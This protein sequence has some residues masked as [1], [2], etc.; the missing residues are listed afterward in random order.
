MRPGFAVV[1]HPMAHV[2]PVELVIALNAVASRSWWFEGDEA[3]S[4]AA[5]LVDASCDPVTAR[6]VRGLL[7]GGL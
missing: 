7:G 4:L 5:A 3:K 1:M 2:A 6:A